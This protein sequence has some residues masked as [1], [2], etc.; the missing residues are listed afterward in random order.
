M[1]LLRKSKSN[2]PK[3]K[4]LAKLL[5][6]NTILMEMI[7]DLMMKYINLK[8]NKKRIKIMTKLNKIRMIKVCI[9]DKQINKFNL[10]KIT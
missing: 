8:S 9:R 3:I 5:R 6:N 4:R 10:A 1:K 7:I 2:Y